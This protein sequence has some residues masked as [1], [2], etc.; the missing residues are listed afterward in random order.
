LGDPEDRHVGGA[1]RAAAAAPRIAR[2]RNASP[3]LS[4]CGRAGRPLARRPGCG[5]HRSAARPAA[6]GQRH[7][8]RRAAVV[9]R[10]C[11]QRTARNGPGGIRL[12]SEI[13]ATAV[14]RGRYSWPALFFCIGEA[15]GARVRR[16][17]S[18]RSRRDGDWVEVHRTAGRRWCPHC[19]GLSARRAAPQR[20][21]RVR[22]RFPVHRGIQ[23]SACAGVGGADGLRPARAAAAV[24][25]AAVR[26]RDHLTIAAAIAL[27]EETGPW[28]P[29]PVPRPRAEPR[30]P[31]RG[32]VPEVDSGTR[33]AARLED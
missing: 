19:A 10:P 13:A 26:G 3:E 5:R 22:V 14:G 17:C 23:R 18:G 9:G 12:L 25:I 32:T 24:Q 21:G 29:A 20:A 8:V 31:Q 6:S 7:L 30:Q 33:A 27:E 28:R 15:I 2:A 4:E 1:A 16:H 11:V